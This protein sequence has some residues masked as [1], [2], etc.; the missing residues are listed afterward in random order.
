MNPSTS[1]ALSRSLSSRP[2]RMR[3]RGFFR[4]AAGGL[5]LPAMAAPA[6]SAAPAG[7]PVKLGLATNG[8]NDLT[9]DEMAQLAADAKL[10]CVQLFF[11]QKDSNYWKY[12]QPVDLSA[13]NEAEC[14]RIAHAYRSRGLEIQALGVYANLIEPDEAAR[15]RNLQYFAEMLRIARAMG[16]GMLLT[17]CGSI[18]VPGKGRDLSASLD[19]R[20]WPRLLD[21][22]RRLIPLAEEHEATIAVE[23]YFQDLLGSA[24][25]VRYFLEEIDHPRV[26]ALLDPANLLPHNTLDE[27]FDALAPHIVALHA[28]DRKLH[29]TK[30]VAA[31]EGDL[32]YRR[33]L[34]L[35]RERCPDV[36]LV[37]E[38]VNPRTYQAA[39]AHVR[40][41]L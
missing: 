30:G 4:A 21:M 2:G 26:R 20:A 36:P 9:N 23:P 7:A 41:F 16:V 11:T 27:M 38:Y 32:D 17:E 25:A 29:V 40:S 39:L 35:A 22:V 19:E 15:E 8:F 34:A 5:A 10:Q 13:V 12:N 3:R 6:L 33:Y 37:L 31:G 24:T 14:R 1:A 18:L 28:K